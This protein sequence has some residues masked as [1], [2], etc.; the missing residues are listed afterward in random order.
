MWLLRWVRERGSRCPLQGVEEAGHAC[1]QGKEG[2]LSRGCRPEGHQCLRASCTEQLVLPIPG[3]FVATTP[4]I[5]LEGHPDEC[6]SQYR[7][8]EGYGGI[9]GNSSEVPGGSS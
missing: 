7:R 8:R 4:H 6:R 5:R 9:Q 2:G 1:L 3:R